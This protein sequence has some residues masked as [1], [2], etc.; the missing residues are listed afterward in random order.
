M[1]EK[2]NTKREKNRENKVEK[3]KR[4]NEIGNK[5]WVNCSKICPSVTNCAAPTG[6]KRWVNCYHIGKWLNYEKTSQNGKTTQ[7]R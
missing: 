6:K 4:E 3:S 1:E 2:K 5:K 7:L